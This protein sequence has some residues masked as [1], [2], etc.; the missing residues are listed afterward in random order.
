MAPATA[1]G[2]WRQ[3]AFTSCQILATSVPQ[4]VLL[5]KI[6]ARESVDCRINNAIAAQLL[7]NFVVDDRTKVRHY[8]R[9]VINGILCLY[10]LRGKRSNL[11]PPVVRFTVKTR[12]RNAQ[13]LCISNVAIFAF[14]SPYASDTLGRLGDEAAAKIQRVVDPSAIDRSWLELVRVRSRCCDSSEK[15]VPDRSPGV[16]DHHT[17]HA[18]SG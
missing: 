16:D 10:S 15:W 14:A 7:V 11:S 9:F 8:R 3:L 13:K 1:C 18:V 12:N 5:P 17:W 6:R 2:V 4:A